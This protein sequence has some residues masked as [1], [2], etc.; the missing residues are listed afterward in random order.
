[1]DILAATSAAFLAGIA[2]GKSVL[3]H[4]CENN[5]E[6]SGGQ[7][8]SLIIPS[9]VYGSLSVPLTVIGSSPSVELVSKYS[10][11]EIPEFITTLDAPVIDESP[12][13]QER[14]SLNQ[15]STQSEPSV[16]RMKLGLPGNA[17]SDSQNSDKI[18]NSNSGRNVIR[19]REDNRRV[20]AA[21]HEKTLVKKEK[22]ASIAAS[23]VQGTQ[24]DT[25]GK[26]KGR[27]LSA[28]PILG[29][30]LPTALAENMRRARIL[31]LGYSI[32]SATLLYQNILR[33]RDESKEERN[34]SQREKQLIAVRQYMKC[35]Q[36][37]AGVAMRIMT[38]HQDI[39]ELKRVQG[40]PRTQL[41][42]SDTME[43]EIPCSLPIQIYS[44]EL[45]AASETNIP[46]WTPGENASDRLDIPLNK[47]MLYGNKSGSRRFVILESITSTSLLDGVLSRQRTYSMQASE[48]QSIMQNEI[49]SRM[50]QNA[51]K[52][53]YADCVGVAHIMIGTTTMKDAGERGSLDVIQSER[54]RLNS[55]DAVA[56]RI[57]QSVELA[58]TAKVKDQSSKDAKETKKTDFHDHI[59][60]A[61]TTAKSEA[62]EN[63][64]SSNI[65]LRVIDSVGMQIRSGGRK[66]MTVTTNT[67]VGAVDTVGRQVRT[68]SQMVL[69]AADSVGDL[70][71]KTIKRSPNHKG[72]IHVFSDDLQLVSF[73]KSIMAPRNFRI[74]WHDIRNDGYTKTLTKKAFDEKSRDM[75]LV[76]TKNDT[77]TIHATIALASIFPVEQKKKIISVLE[78]GSSRDTLMSLLRAEDEFITEPICVESIHEEL[79]AHAKTILVSE[80]LEANQVEDV[81]LSRLKQ[82]DI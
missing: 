10:H 75:F 30:T 66:V 44:Q 25:R 65:L 20:V 57:I 28:A 63:K 82:K 69:D 46:V 19:M 31:L 16:R 23:Q 41:T 47:R 49:S 34:H 40:N 77:S 68:A 54:I 2:E 73:A 36:C 59:S 72:T 7:E 5:K 62:E 81:I 61:A 27:S 53:K 78:K 22:D 9:L 4:H 70:L 51:V 56:S 80:R 24:N 37:K 14:D 12:K 18:T 21:M 6:S 11:L 13:N 17:E 39:S 8:Q 50:I 35:K 38:E 33:D 71:I 60:Q 3:K 52:V 29:K 64:A 45:Q 48:R 76:I 55:M 67:V 26:Q 74:I 79:I 58:L 1:M 32:M 43:I 15:Q 42:N